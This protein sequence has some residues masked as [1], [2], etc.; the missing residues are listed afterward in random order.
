MVE[1]VQPHAAWAAAIYLGSEFANGRDRNLDGRC[2][3]V[4]VAEPRHWA[5]LTEQFSGWGLS[6]LEPRLYRTAQY[7]RIQSWGRRVKAVLVRSDRA[8]PP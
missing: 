5:G 2:G 3:G 6:H 4:V 7:F 1:Y 8:R